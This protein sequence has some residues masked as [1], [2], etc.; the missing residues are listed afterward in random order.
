MFMFMFRLQEK[1]TTM[2]MGAFT[3]MDMDM[4]WIR[5]MNTAWIWSPGMGMDIPLLAQNTFSDI[6]MSDIRH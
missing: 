5:K 6:W 1:E 3:N 2:D 4:S